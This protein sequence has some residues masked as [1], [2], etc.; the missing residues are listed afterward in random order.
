MLPMGASRRLAAVIGGV[1][2]GLGTG[3]ILFAAGVVPDG[4]TPPIAIGSGTA[5]LGL[6]L[7]VAALIRD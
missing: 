7:M 6:G 4:A 5:G 2:A 1:L 3:G